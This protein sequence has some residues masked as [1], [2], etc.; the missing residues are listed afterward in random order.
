MKYLLFSFFQPISI[1]T[2]YER[3][4]EELEIAIV[5]QESEEKIFDL[6]DQGRCLS[7]RHIRFLR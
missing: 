5:K 6:L 2:S 7:N 1:L 4:M 3:K